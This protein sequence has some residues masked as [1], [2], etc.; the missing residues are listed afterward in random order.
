M[1]L[2]ETRFDRNDTLSS[3]RDISIIRLGFTLALKF[4]YKY[5]YLNIRTAYLYGKLK[6]TVKMPNQSFE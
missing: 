3:D 5:F 4:G 1:A 2:P 6:E